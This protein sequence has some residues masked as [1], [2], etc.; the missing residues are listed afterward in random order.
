M[1]ALVKDDAGAGF[2]DAVMYP[3]LVELGDQLVDNRDDIRR[4]EE[5]PLPGRKA[6]AGEIPQADN[7]R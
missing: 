7:Q 3:E 2:L 5:C 6:F 1:L 4:P